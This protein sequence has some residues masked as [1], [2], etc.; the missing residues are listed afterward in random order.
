MN[1]SYKGLAIGQSAS[2]EK[3]FTAEDIGEYTELT[4]DANFEDGTVPG[5][6][7]GGMISNLLGTKLP[8]RGTNW[9]KQ[10]YAFPTRACVGETI[11]ATVEIVRIR[12]EKDLVNL[13]VRCTAPGGKVV[14]RGESLVLV[15]DLDT[16][17]A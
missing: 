8:G 17:E 16:V 7:L 4:G 12:P 13:R 9:L 3:V 6:L 14:C 1:T 15:K 2:I 5:P 11:T 10:R